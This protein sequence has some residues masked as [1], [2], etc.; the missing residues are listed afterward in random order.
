MVRALK[1]AKQT[2]I[3]ARTQAV[4]AVKGLVVMAPDPIREQLH[5]LK[6]A[7]LVRTCSA[8]RVDRASDPTFL[9]I[10]PPHG[11]LSL[12]GLAIQI[13]YTSAKLNAKTGRGPGSEPGASSTGAGHV[14]A[15][16][17]RAVP[18]WSPESDAR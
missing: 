10:S 7:A 14:L 13:G 3:K 4:N 18:D 8:Y 2:A 12:L 1:I 16:F 6:T 17:G 15:F 5:H 11:S 9:R